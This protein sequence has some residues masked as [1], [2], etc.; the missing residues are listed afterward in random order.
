MKAREKVRHKKISI[1]RIILEGIE[2]Y[3][4]SFLSY[5]FQ[6]IILEGIERLKEITRLS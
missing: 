3:T 2:S 5:N 4:L 6:R 1:K